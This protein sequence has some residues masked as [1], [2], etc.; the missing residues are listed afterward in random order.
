MLIKKGVFESMD[1]P[2]FRPIN[3][4][5]GKCVDFCMEDVAFCLRAKEKGFKV[6]IDPTI[7]VLHEKKVLL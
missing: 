3:Q 4:K 2:W 6:Y 5:I 7:R 1:Y